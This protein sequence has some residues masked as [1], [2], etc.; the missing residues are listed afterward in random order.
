MSQADGILMQGTTVDC[1]GIARFCPFC[2]ERIGRPKS[3]RTFGSPQAVGRQWFEARDSI[4]AP[5]SLVTNTRD[6]NC[7]Q[8]H[9]RIVTVPFRFFR[10]LSGGRKTGAW[11]DP[12]TQGDDDRYERLWLPCLLCA[13]PASCRSVAAFSELLQRTHDPRRSTRH[14]PASPKTRRSN[15]CAHPRPRAA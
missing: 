2:P 13:R 7:L 8:R 15:A 9:C 6:I 3:D 14:S 5:L 12:E 4:I 11:G 10:P 1:Q